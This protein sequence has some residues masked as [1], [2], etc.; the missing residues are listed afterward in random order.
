MNAPRSANERFYASIVVPLVIAALIVLFAQYHPPAVTAGAP[1]SFTTI[2]IATLYTLGRIAIAY[3]LSLV[4]ALP[5]ALLAVYSRTLE[6]VLLPIYDVF[7]SI[8]NLAIFPIILVFFF[9]LGF[10]DGA[11]ITILFLNMV[12]N[13]VFALVG[14]LKIIP[15]DIT[16]AAHVFGIERFQYLRKVVL[17]AVFPQI[18]TGSIL[19]VAEGWNLIIVAEA[20]HSYLPGGT[21]AQDLFGIGTVLV[22]TA[23]QGQNSSYLLAFVVM[24]AI[25]AVFNFLVWQRLLIYAQ[26]FRFE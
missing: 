15:K 1:V 7:E 13:L 9:S 23:A 12:W 4:V 6:S 5:L 24:V 3:V 8:P 10:L 26:R 22:S 11:A 17:P 20:L 18:V 25:I 21:P 19:A 14:G 16:Y 2:V